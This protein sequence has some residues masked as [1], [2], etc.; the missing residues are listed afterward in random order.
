MSRTGY[1]ELPSCG[2]IERSAGHASDEAAWKAVGRARLSLRCWSLD[3]PGQALS[4]HSR[5][6]WVLLQ[7]AWSRKPWV[8][9]KCWTVIR[10]RATEPVASVYLLAWRRGC[11]G[12][13]NGQ[14]VR[15]AAGRN[16]TV[17][18]WRWSEGLRRAESTGKI[19][20]KVWTAEVV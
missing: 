1:S 9:C 13:G 10:Q 3:D 16:P 17:K 4:E 15:V 11:T 12:D 5:L 14:W 6:A 8:T 2:D 20:R 7:K 19:V 18:I